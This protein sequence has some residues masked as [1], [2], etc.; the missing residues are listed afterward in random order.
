MKFVQFP[1]GKV[2]PVDA[3]NWITGSIPTPAANSHDDSLE[4]FLDNLSNEVTGSSGGLTD[5]SYQ[6]RGSIISFHGAASELPDEESEYEEN[7]F[8]LLDLDSAELKRQLA[9]QYQLSDVELDHALRYLDTEYGAETVLRLADSHRELRSAAHLDECD[10]VRVV[11]GG[12]EVAYWSSE[13]WSESS[14]E[15]MGAIFGA[16]LGAQGK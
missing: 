2:W 11:V 14:V 8:K 1:N 7:G 15:V 3:D 16:A 4:T 12:L 9:L 5:F 10:Y 13:E 6:R